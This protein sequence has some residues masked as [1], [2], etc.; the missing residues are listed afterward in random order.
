MRF[1]NNK[2]KWILLGLTGLAL[3]ATIAL[4]DL[5][6]QLKTFGDLMFPSRSDA[7]LY[8]FFA[9]FLLLE[10]ALLLPPAWFRHLRVTK[11]HL[12]AAV[13][14]LAII[15]LASYFYFVDTYRLNY[16][17]SFIASSG[18]DYSSTRLFHNHVLKP[19]QAIP[20]KLMGINLLSGYDPGFPYYDLMPHWFYG[21]GFFI[22]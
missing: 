8:Y 4:P 1:K 10:I 20:L 14:I 16:R 17:G 9:Y 3:I 2:T 15:N 7:K 18:D 13:I 6:L 5:R 22:I 21:L 11:K 12:A 19:V